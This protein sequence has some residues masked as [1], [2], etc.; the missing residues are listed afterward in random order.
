[1]QFQSLQHFQI[2]FK[3]GYT[4]IRGSAHPVQRTQATAKRARGP[5]SGSKGDTAR[6]RATASSSSAIA[7]D[8]GRARVRGLT[9]STRNYMTKHL[10]A[11]PPS[12]GHRSIGY[13]AGNNGDGGGSYGTGPS[14]RP[15]ELERGESGREDAQ[16]HREADGGVGEV[17]GLPETEESTTNGG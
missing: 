14:R 1:M 4:G 5:L 7:G 6:A 3:M 17:G 16:A 10:R 13:L 15:S 2:V 11:A 8:S 12:N 9:R